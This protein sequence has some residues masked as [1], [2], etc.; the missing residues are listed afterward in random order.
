MIPSI[1]NNPL[2]PTDSIAP[3]PA[4]R[5]LRILRVQSDSAVASKFMQR[6]Y[7]F[8][9]EADYNAIKA[10]LTRKGMP[11]GDGPR[12]AAFI[13]PNLKQFVNM[14]IYDPSNPPEDDYE[15]LGMIKA[16]E[17]TQSDFE[18]QKKQNKDHFRDYLIESVDG[19]RIP[20]LPVISGW[21]TKV[22]MDKT[23]FVAFDEEDPDAMY[24]LLYL[25]KLPVMQ[26]DGQ[27]QTAALFA[28][29]ATKDAIQKG[30]LDKFRIT[31]E[32]EL[33]VN[34]RQAGQSFA[35]RNG[36]GSKKNKNLVI[37][38]DTS[39]ALSDLRVKSV[40]GTIFERRLAHG[41]STST[42]ETATKFI[43]DLSTMEQ[44]LMGVIADGKAKPEAFKHFH[45]EHF[46]KYSREFIELL[47]SLFGSSWVEKSPANQDPFRRLYVHGWPF[48]LKAIA[49]A[50]HQ[51][52]I[53]ELGP[54]ASALGARRDASKT[55]EEEFLE[56][57]AT[58][59]TEWQKKPAVPFEELKERLQQI[60]WLRYRH[61]WIVLTGAKM[62]DGKKRA[63]R[64]KSTGEE[65]VQGQA[66]NTKTVIGSV[67]DKILSETWTDLTEKVDEPLDTVT[68]SPSRRRSQQTDR[69]R[70][71]KAEG[72]AGEPA[73]E[74]VA[75]EL[76]PLIP[77]AS[78][79]ETGS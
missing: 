10:T 25:P 79:S 56:E 52:R 42:S 30:A 64:L 4:Y 3:D 8:L 11:A 53:D 7:R 39:S 44:M 23:V 74:V 47:D 12:I 71:V 73:Q 67:R 40:S 32:I 49:S 27:T 46:A 55:F 54:L 19:S 15:A 33:N 50:Y 60:D 61:H 36:R 21:Q 68:N 45:I 51:S 62:K 6:E 63:M 76:E 72:A 18:G 9:H 31:L 2:I 70:Q 34:E 48:A 75:A 37:G 14:V 58:K 20:Y 29:R 65:K 1:P 17:Q 24:G 5:G 16:H 26:A 35:D 69:T 59:R 13:H 41:R 22:A 38:L 66:Q 78:N 43:V 77:A 28:L 57:L